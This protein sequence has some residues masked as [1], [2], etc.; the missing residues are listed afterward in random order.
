MCPI[1]LGV[2]PT[3]FQKTLISTVKHDGGRLKGW[4]IYASS[5]QKF[6]IN[7]IE[8]LLHDLKETIHEGE[9]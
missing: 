6:D 2:K 3:L 4:S 9:P 8:M 5:G 1:T 7:V